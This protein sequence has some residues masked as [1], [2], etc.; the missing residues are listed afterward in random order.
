MKRAVLRTIS[1]FENT[2]LT[3]KS[4]AVSFATVVAVRVFI[5][6]LVTGYSKQTVVD[7]VG[8]L[9]H[10]TFVFFLVS[11]LI[12]LLFVKLITNEET[13]KIATVLLWGQWLIVLPPVIDRLIFKENPYKSFYLFGSVDEVFRK[14]FLFFGDSPHYGI[15]YGTRFLILVTIVFLAFYAFVKTRS[16]L[17]VV[18]MAVGAYFLLYLLGAFPS[19]VTFFWT[20]V[21]EGTVSE[22]KAHTVAGDF[23]TPLRYF[24]FELNSFKYVIHFKLAFYYNLLLVVCLLILQFFEN[25][26][27]LFALFRNVRVPQTIYQIGLMFVGF[28]MAIFFEKTG[29]RFNEVSFLVL[30]NATLAV[31]LAWL[32]SVVVNDL[33]DIRIDEKSNTKRPLVQRVFS[34]VE[35]REYAFLYAFLAL[36]SGLIVG[37]PSFVLIGLFLLITWAYSSYPFRLRRIVFVSSGV[38]AL[39]SLLILIAG[40]FLGTGFDSPE[41]F[42]WRIIGFLFVVYTLVVPIKD[43][44][45]I[46]ADKEEDVVTLPNLVGEKNARLIL[47]V[48]VFFCYMS[49]VWVV[50]EMRLFWP[51]LFF[52]LISYG[53]LNRRKM[54]HQK[55]L[56]SLLLSVIVYGALLVWVAIF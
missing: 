2:P 43:L 26:K 49:S 53:F 8:V 23:F 41:I 38:S 17:K 47:A 56:Y 37:F 51:A 33:E 30:L 36:L 22:V 5:E 48:I 19:L 32:F 1:F 24:G 39:A 29:E 35:Y 15:T 3:I 16:Y 55:L 40:F 45:D 42:P 14:F 21:G 54:K 12:V 11:Y 13:K 10:G 20:F 46:V 34:V 9:I 50:N 27:K 18:F 52:G 25:K 4:W 6:Q 44:K 28:G 31:V 7:F